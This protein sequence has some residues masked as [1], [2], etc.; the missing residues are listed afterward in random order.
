MTREI[1]CNVMNEVLELITEQGLDGMAEAYRILLNEAMKAE[2]SAVLNAG[3]YERSPDRRGYANGFKPKTLATRS[4]HVT[5]SSI[6]RPWKRASAPSE[7]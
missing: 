1:E 2:R 5:S 3:A 6:P 7:P 4:R